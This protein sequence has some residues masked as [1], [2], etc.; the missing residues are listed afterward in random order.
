MKGSSFYATG[1]RKESV[2]RVWLTPG[3]GKIQ[4]NKQELMNYFRRPTLEMVIRQPLVLTQTEA[5]FDVSATVRGGGLSGQADAMVLGIS[6]AILKANEELKK[7][8]RD[9]GFLTRDPRE[10]ERKK[11]GQPGA[12][13]R[14]QFSK[15]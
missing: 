3:E 12:R 14:F 1:R 13:K 2:A 5:Q 8:L 11:Y 9:A 4:V 15:R 10:K 7:P 6:R